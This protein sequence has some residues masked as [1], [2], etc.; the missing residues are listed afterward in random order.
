[1]E[2]P[3]SNKIQLEVARILGLEVQNECLPGVQASLQL[4]ETHAAILRRYTSELREEGK[5]ELQQ[6]SGAK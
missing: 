1:M 2:Q 3:E 4:L 5:N 6:C